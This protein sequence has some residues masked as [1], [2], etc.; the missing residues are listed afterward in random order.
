MDSLTPNEP[1]SESL[2]F[3]TGDKLK[4]LLTTQDGKKAVRAHQT[5]LTL[6]DSATSLSE[7]FPFTSKDNGK[8]K[9]E[10]VRL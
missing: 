8:A 7:S 6:T 10:L 2:T 5:F 9:V 3:D 1:L 4:I